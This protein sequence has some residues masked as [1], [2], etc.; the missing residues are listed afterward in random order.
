MIRRPDIEIRVVVLAVQGAV[1][2]LHLKRPHLILAKAFL[3]II[4]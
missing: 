4:R 1:L 2:S 3:P